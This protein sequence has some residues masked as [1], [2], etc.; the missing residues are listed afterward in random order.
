MTIWKRWNDS[1][2]EWEQAS[3]IATSLAGMT[4]T[5]SATADTIMSRD[6]NGRAKVANPSVSTDIA[7]KQYV[8]DII[9]TGVIVMWSG[10]LANIPSGWALCNGSGGTPDL[11]DRFILGAAS[12]EEP[13]ATGGSHNRTLTTTNI[14]SHTHGFTTNA[15]GTNHT[16][17]FTTG[18]TSVSHTHS[19]TTA[20]ESRS[21][22][23]SGTTGSNNRTHTH[24]TSTAGNHSHRYRRWV[25]NWVSRGGGAY[26]TDAGHEDDNRQTWLSGSHTHPVG[27]NS[28]THNHA[29]TSG[30]ASQTHTHS[31]TTGSHSISHNHTGTTGGRN[32]THTH[33]GTTNSTGGGTAF[34]NRPSYYKLAFIMK[35]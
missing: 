14:P 20:T 35:T 32:T 19:G 1:N 29:F 26:Y 30:N 18:N 24:T 21:H 25:G 10:T 2:Q 15:E 22:T 6:S 8:D 27:D 13:G 3:A 9:P 17:T 31:F 5:S 11:R 16:H 4:P 34:D 33:T 28:R 12:G 23:H 7:N